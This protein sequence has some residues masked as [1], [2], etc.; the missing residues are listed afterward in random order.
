VSAGQLLCGG[1]FSTDPVSNWLCAAAL[2]HVFMDNPVSASTALHC[3]ALHCTAQAVQTELLRVQLAT[4]P[5]AAPV[6]LLVQALRLLQHC[7]A[8]EMTKR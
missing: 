2:S 8:T 4:V 6:P 7:A 5:G 1:L 3:T